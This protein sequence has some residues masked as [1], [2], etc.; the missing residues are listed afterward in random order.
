[1]YWTYIDV[2][3]QC[4]LRTQ[5]SEFRRSVNIGKVPVRWD[6]F[7]FEEY[8]QTNKQKPD[9]YK[10]VGVLIKK[11]KTKTNPRVA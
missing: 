10:T 8:I 3:F 5:I 9:C 6:S 11:N 4:S 1:M 7:C 2:V